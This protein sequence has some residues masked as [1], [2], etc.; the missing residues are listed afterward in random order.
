MW[1]VWESGANTYMLL[2]R[3]P[4][5]KC[6]PGRPRHTWKDNIKIDLK[7]ELMNGIHL[8]QDGNKWRA[9]VNAVTNL[10]F[11]KMRGIS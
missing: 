2:V 10:R 4:E 11:H 1:H 5:R 3:K 7:Q 6:P 8:T 9:L